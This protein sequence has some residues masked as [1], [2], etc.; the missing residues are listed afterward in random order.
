M[1]TIG[2][3]GMHAGEQAARRFADAWPA[4]PYGGQSLGRV[5]AAQRPGGYR[6]LS[7]TAL[8]PGVPPGI[9]QDPALVGYDAHTRHNIT[10]IY[11]GCQNVMIYAAEGRVELLLS[12]DPSGNWQPI[13][14][15]AAEELSTRLYQAARAARDRGQIHKA[16][17]EGPAN[18]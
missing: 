2:P 9:L 15:D 14:P 18:V 8:S 5:G 16:Q 17:K 7:A 12:M 1:E 3:A 10:Q 13:T 11:F 6:P 4:N